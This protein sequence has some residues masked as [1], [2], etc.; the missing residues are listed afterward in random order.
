MGRFSTV[1]G[2]VEATFIVFFTL[3]IGIAA[4]LIEIRLV[5]V[6]GSFLFLGLGLAFNAIVQKKNKRNHYQ[7]AE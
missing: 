4:E 6:V 1:F 7:A 5:Y 3:A 2:L